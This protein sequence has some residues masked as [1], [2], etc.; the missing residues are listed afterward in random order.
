VGYS[1]ILH[2]TG[3]IIKWSQAESKQLDISIQESCL[4]CISASILFND[5]VSLD[6]TVVVVYFLWKIP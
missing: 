4:L 6:E 2:Y 3:G 5:D 1:S